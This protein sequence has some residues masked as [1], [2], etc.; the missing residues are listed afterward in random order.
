MNEKQHE[1]TA[2]YLELLEEASTSQTILEGDLRTTHAAF[3]AC[4]KQLLTVESE[5]NKELA[6]QRG[7]VAAITRDRDALIAVIDQQEVALQLQN[8]QSDAGAAIYSTHIRT[9][10]YQLHNDI[11]ISKTQRI[12]THKRHPFLLLFPYTPHSHE[13]LR[14][15][16]SSIGAI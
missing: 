13:G 8:R 9:T 4:Q 11:T 12:S 16:S 5:C 7:E 1:R 15:A 2:E 3:V 6:R 14:A 10:Q